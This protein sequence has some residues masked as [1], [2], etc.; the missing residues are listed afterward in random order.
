V[1]NRKLAA[2]TVGRSSCKAVSA[3][4]FRQAFPAG[5]GSSKN[6][7]FRLLEAWRNLCL[8]LSEMPLLWAGHFQIRF[9][10][11]KHAGGI[12]GLSPLIPLGTPRGM[13]FAAPVHVCAPPLQTIALCRWLRTTT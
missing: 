9:D 12:S 4:T 1:A 13:A 7:A 11:S 3:S 5:L 8:T 10:T 6:F 2:A